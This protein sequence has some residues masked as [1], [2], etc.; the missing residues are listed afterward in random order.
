MVKSHGYGFIPAGGRVH[1][2][3]DVIKATTE[4]V[5]RNTWRPIVPIVT[6]I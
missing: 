6:D 1:K 3:T 2:E 4:L 5:S